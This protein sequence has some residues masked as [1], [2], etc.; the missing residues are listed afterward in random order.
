MQTL[1]RIGLYGVSGVGKTTILNELIQLSSNILWLEGS[2]LVLDAANLT[3][4]KFKDLPE[5]QK[6]RFREMAISNAIEI[7]KSKNQ[8]VI[9]DGHLAFARGENEFENVMTEMDKMFY[10]DF[11][12]LKLSPITILERQEK[13]LLRNRSYSLETITNWQKFELSELE[14]V[15]EEKNIG[16]YVTESE[17]N[18]DC[19]EL[20]LK[21]IFDTR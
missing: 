3:L 18:K 4:E 14:K 16:L 2:S 5:T 8:H 6:Y 19:M 10:T 15:C 9:I 11:V 13:D 20:I 17:R 7:Q 21:T 12:Y 1:K